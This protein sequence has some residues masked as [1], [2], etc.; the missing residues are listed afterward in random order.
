L[1]G[2]RIFIL[3]DILDVLPLK[4]FRGGMPEIY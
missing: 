2:G 4:I 1:I 3:S